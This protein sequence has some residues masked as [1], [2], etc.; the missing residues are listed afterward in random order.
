MDLELIVQLIGPT[1]AVAVVAAF[2]AVIVTRSNTYRIGK[3]EQQLVADR[4]E[5]REDHKEI[6]ELIIKVRDEM[7]TALEAVRG[8]KQ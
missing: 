5:N 7:V 6:K 1:L 2:G 8:E 3:V 4:T